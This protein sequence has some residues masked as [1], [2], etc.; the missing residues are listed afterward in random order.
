MDNKPI[1]KITD[2]VP[3]TQDLV[4]LYYESCATDPSSIHYKREIIRP[5]INFGWFF[6]HLFLVFGIMSGVGVGLW[7]AFST[8]WVS[9]VAPI[10]LLVIYTAIRLKAF[11]ICSV[12]LY[13]RLAPKKVRNRCRFEPSCSHYMIGAIEKY[14]ALKGFGKGFLRICRCRPPNGGYD[15]P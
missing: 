6:L 5:K 15:E 8:L 10:V 14:G 7:Y 11:M 12:K 13:Q 9:I 1:E 3:T 2:Q 4:D